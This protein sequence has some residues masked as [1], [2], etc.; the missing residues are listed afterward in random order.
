MAYGDSENSRCE[1]V[2]SE[3]CR[4]HAAHPSQIGRYNS[5]RRPLEARPVLS[6]RTVSGLKGDVGGAMV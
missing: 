4:V 3:C 5:R 6:V 1:S 2:Y